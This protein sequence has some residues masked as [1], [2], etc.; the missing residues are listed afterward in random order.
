MVKNEDVKQFVE[1]IDN[2]ET[3]DIMIMLRVSERIRD[4]IPKST[5]QFF[6]R[7]SVEILYLILNSPNKIEILKKL[8]FDDML[9]DFNKESFMKNYFTPLDHQNNSNPIELNQ[10]K[11]DINVL[12]E[13]LSIYSSIFSKLNGVIKTNFNKEQGDALVSL[14]KD[15][16]PILPTQEQVKVIEKAKLLGG[17]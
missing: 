16:K 17:K 15:Y 8:G 6:L 2:K 4:I 11:E 9:Y 10:L 14:N 5:Q 13:A 1:Q 7:R 3:T 12:K